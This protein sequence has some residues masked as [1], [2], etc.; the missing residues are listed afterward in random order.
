MTDQIW[1]SISKNSLSEYFNTIN[2]SDMEDFILI[3]HDFWLHFR[4]TEYFENIYKELVLYFFEK[5]GD[6]EIDIIVEDVGVNEEMV[7]SDIIQLVSPGIETALKI[8]YIEERIRFR[9]ESFY[10]SEQAE[11]LI[12]ESLS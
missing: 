10:F 3:G 12:K 8:G 4:K 6:N 7:V 9:L 2:S 11:S 1:S 5:Y